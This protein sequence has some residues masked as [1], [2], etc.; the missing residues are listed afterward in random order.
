MGAFLTTFITKVGDFTPDTWPVLSP[1][2]SKHITECKNN[3]RRLLDEVGP[4]NPIIVVGARVSETPR[5][6]RGAIIGLC[7]LGDTIHKT[8]DVIHE[9]HRNNHNNLRVSDRKF[10][11][12]YGIAISRAIQYTPPYVDAREECDEATFATWLRKPFFMALSQPESD[13]LSAR[14][15]EYDGLYIEP[16]AIDSVVNQQTWQQTRTGRTRGPVPSN[17]QVSYFQNAYSET[18]TYLFQFAD[19]NCWKIGRTSRLVTK[20][21]C[22]INKH[23]PHQL[24]DDKV[25]REHFHKVWGSVEKAHIMEQRVLD[26]LENENCLIQGEIIYCEES[27]LRSAWQRAIDMIEHQ[28]P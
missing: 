19:E 9:S 15:S 28:N 21:L 14:L 17:A 2:Y 18:T 3:C 26:Q 12:P 4:D 27:Q 8:E 24:L 5:A 25:W 23:I 10:R 6:K 7:F 22:E 16:P 13:R 1:W 11:W 20:R